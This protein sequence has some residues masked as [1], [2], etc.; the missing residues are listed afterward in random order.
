MMVQSKATGSKVTP[1]NVHDGKLIGNYKV[2]KLFGIEFVVPP[3]LYLAFI[4]FTITVGPSL[5]QLI[6]LNVKFMEN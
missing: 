2:K 6:H 4:S 5:Y 3:Q 1:S